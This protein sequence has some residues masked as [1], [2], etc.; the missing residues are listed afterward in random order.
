MG[1]IHWISLRVSADRRQ[2]AVQRLQGN[3]RVRDD[4]PADK[5]VQYLFAQI[6]Q[7]GPTERRAWIKLAEY[8]LQQE[9]SRASTD[10]TRP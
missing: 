3:G 7:G 6:S 5:V 9:S 1:F 4:K 2:H 10:L 8:L